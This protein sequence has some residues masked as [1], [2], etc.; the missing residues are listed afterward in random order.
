MPTMM[1]TAATRIAET[2]KE[3]SMITS[4]LA[5]LV[6]RIPQDMTAMLVAETHLRGFPISGTCFARFCDADLLTRLVNIFIPN[7]VFS[8]RNVPW[9]HL[10]SPIFQPTTTRVGLR[11]LEPFV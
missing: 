11:G 10:I 2:Q 6:K 1:T 9:V 4:T 5:L 8:V 3:G 7:T